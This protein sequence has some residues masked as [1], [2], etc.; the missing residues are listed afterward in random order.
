MGL[1]KRIVV[2]TSSCESCSPSDEGITLQLTGLQNYI[3]CNTNNLNHVDKTDFS[4]SQNGEFFTDTDDKEEDGWGAC[5]ES[6]LKGEVNAA[7]V[8][9]VGSGG[10]TDNDVNVW[11]CSGDGSSLSANQEMALTCE[12]QDL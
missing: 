1:L 3:K 6:A 4:P 2:K 7:V 5:Y 11:V 12:E 10:W 8:S 9:W